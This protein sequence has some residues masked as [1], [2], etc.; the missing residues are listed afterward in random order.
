MTA[1][2]GRIES[3]NSC[4]VTFA[5]SC[6]IDAEVCNRELLGFNCVVALLTAPFHVEI[7]VFGLFS[8]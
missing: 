3:W 8:G 4:F 7:A 5:A 6:D 1:D 2:A